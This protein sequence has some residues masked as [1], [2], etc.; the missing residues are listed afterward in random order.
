MLW[1]LTLSVRLDLCVQKDRYDIHRL[2]LSKRKT[3]KNVWAD[4]PVFYIVNIYL[5]QRISSTV[6]FQWFCT[7]EIHES[8]QKYFS[9]QVS[10]LVQVVLYHKGSISLDHSS[11]YPTLF[12]FQRSLGFF[13]FLN[14]CCW[15]NYSSSVF[16]CIWAAFFTQWHGPVSRKEQK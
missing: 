16:L 8:L 6:A 3:R 5:L 10:F 9:R 7:A 1:F 13:Y 12:S 14:Q 15:C 4:Y 2:P 11:V